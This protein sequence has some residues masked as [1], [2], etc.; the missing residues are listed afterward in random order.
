[1]SSSL[2]LNQVTRTITSR[3]YV[4]NYNINVCDIN[5]CVFILCGSWSIPDDQYLPMYGIFNDDGNSP[6]QQRTAVSITITVFWS[7]VLHP[8]TK[9]DG[10][11]F[12][13]TVTVPSVNFNTSHHVLGQVCV[14]YNVGYVLAISE[15]SKI[16]TA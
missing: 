2:K 4:V 13:K 3:H 7:I 10:V 14:T 15:K 9:T 5:R 16:W 6:W 11:T 12:Q 8:S 1:M